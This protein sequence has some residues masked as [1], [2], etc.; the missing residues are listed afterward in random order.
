MAVEYNIALPP[1]TSP[2]VVNAMRAAPPIEPFDEA[3]ALARVQRITFLRSLHAKGPVTDPALRA[4]WAAHQQ[5]VAAYSQVKAPKP[6]A[7]PAPLP[8]AA[9]PSTP[10][11]TVPAAPQPTPA[12][13][14]ITNRTAQRAG[15]SQA[16]NVIGALWNVKTPFYYRQHTDLRQVRS[17][18]EAP[19]APTAGNPP[20]ER[21]TRGRVLACSSSLRPLGALHSLG[22]GRFKR[23]ACPK[24]HPRTKE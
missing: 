6:P 7:V 14:A 13:A 19:N 21:F 3:K 16:A 24:I 12:F 22:A 18:V 4:E 17:L 15:L 1:L 9:V 8:T 11:P 10:R 23:P 2:T 20:R 5:R